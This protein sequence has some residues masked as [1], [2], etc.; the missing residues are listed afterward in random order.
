[1]RYVDVILHPDGTLWWYQPIPDEFGE[2]YEAAAG[3]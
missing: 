2:R 1:V 3:G